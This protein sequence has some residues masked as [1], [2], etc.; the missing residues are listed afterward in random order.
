MGSSAIP[1]P[2]VEP[3]HLSCSAN[4]Q[5]MNSELCLNRV[6]TVFPR[7]E[8]TYPRGQ[9][10]RFIGLVVWILTSLDCSCC[11]NVSWSFSFLKVSLA[12]FVFD[13]TIQTSRSRRTKR[14]NSQC[15]TQLHTKRWN[16][17]DFD[18]MSPTWLLWKEW[19]DI[20][21]EAAKTRKP[22]AFPGRKV[23]TRSVPEHPTRALSI[24][25]MAQ[26]QERLP[27]LRRE[28]IRLFR[29]VHGM[30]TY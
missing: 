30:A 2:Q 7:Y 20:S 6:Y 22:C 17:G 27:L 13:N 16:H 3:M 19:Q 26:I 8:K 28:Q 15:A 25:R 11:I 29:L 5:S 21:C 23:L 1:S 12:P 14:N 4:T 10:R 24:P 18:P 9:N